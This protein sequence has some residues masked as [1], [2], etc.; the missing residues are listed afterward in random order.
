MKISKYIEL[1]KQFEDKTFEGNYGVLDNILH[2]SSFLGN[3]ASIFFAFFFLNQL[4]TKTTSDFAGRLIIIGIASVVFLT[5]FEL[6]KRFVLKS[7]S[8]AFLRSKKFTTDVVYNATFAAILLAGS[9]Y[10]SLNGAKVF[11][12]QSEKVEQQSAIAVSS[13]IDSLNSIF[14]EQ[15]AYKIAERNGVIKNRDMITSKIEDAVY[16]SRLKEYNALIQQNNEEIRRVDAEIARLREEKKSNITII[17]EE[18]SSSSIIKV[19]K[20]F[21]NQIAFIL[22]SSFIEILILVGI[23]FHSFFISKVYGELKNNAENIERYRIHQVYMDLLKMFYGVS[24]NLGTLQVNDPETTGEKLNYEF[25][26]VVSPNT[27]ITNYNS[28]KAFYVHNKANGKIVKEF[29]LTCMDLKILTIDDA[30]QKMSSLPY[31]EAK[32][33][34]SNYF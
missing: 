16:T 30:K 15:L 11:A 22:I 25:K 18:V 26:K 32:K 21:K 10:L 12:D 5:G 1:E 29:I 34:L 7:F 3:A 6:L 33:V 4:L 28:I 19:N 14:D 9:F 2:Y 27:I 13:Q 24:T 8:F 20:I 31:G 23:F 17:K